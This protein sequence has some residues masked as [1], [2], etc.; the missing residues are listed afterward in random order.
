MATLTAIAVAAL[1]WM[2]T[3]LTLFALFFHEVIEGSEGNMAAGF[4][5][6]AAVP[7]VVFWWMMHHAASHF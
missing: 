2:I 3:I 4:M 1:A 6:Q 7:M 5:L